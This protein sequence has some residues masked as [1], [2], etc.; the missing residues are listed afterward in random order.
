VPSDDIG[1]AIWT[2]PGRQPVF[3]VVDGGKVVDCT[4][5]AEPWAKGRSA[6]QLL[7]R[8]ER[9][10]VKV[11]W[12][13]LNSVPTRRSAH[14]VERTRLRHWATKHDR[15]IV[16]TLEFGQTADGFTVDDGT[17]PHLWIYPDRDDAVRE[18]RRRLAV[19]TWWRIAADHDAQ[20]RPKPD[21]ELPSEW[22]VPD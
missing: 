20:G 21:P 12:I 10:G 7:E 19:G 4:P 11:E 16:S 15:G 17:E 14:L 22:G 5:F 6:A 9:L 2:E 1:M 8:A 3:L 18:V 13:P